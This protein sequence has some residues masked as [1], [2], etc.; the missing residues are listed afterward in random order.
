MSTV[1]GGSQCADNHW[2][3]PDHW[4]T[5]LQPEMWAWLTDDHSLTER[6]ERYAGAVSVEVLD[7]RWTR[8]R[9]GG[10]PSQPG[11]CREVLLHGDGQPWVY[12]CSLIPARTLSH[13]GLDTLGSQPLGKIL[14]A[15]PHCQRGPIEIGRFS[16]RSCYGELAAG[17]GQTTD[18]DLWGRRSLFYL[19]DDPLQITE[20]FLP[21]APPY[22]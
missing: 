9:S 7:E 10:L 14:F 21:A 17:L 20:I 22:R 16:P 5:E 3:R 19:G 2:Y 11:L 1:C 15:S 8:C 12:A 13:A 4:R 18:T 6:L